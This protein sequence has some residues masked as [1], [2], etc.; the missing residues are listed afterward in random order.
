MTNQN[1]D[2]ISFVFFGTP[3]V[4]SKTLDVLKSFRLTPKLIVTNPDRPKGRG[5]KLAPSPTATW[6][7]EHG[8]P[9]LKPEKIDEEFYTKISELDTDIFIVVAY[10]KILP[11]RLIDMPKYGTLNIHYSLLPKY[12]GASP[13]ESALLAGDNETGVSIQK[14]VL[15][16]DQGPIIKDEKVLIDINTE[17][18]ELRAILIEKGGELLANILPDYIDG[19]ITP[20]PQ[21][22]SLATYCSKIE[23]SDGEIDPD[24]DAILNW[25]KYRAYSGWPGVFFFKDGKRVK[26]TRAKFKDGKFLIERV[27]PEGKKEQDYLL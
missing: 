23:K 9:C 15:K 17:K 14:M 4:G 11:Q 6:A 5:L 13:V 10:G 1:N 19:K 2:K 18:E 27:V 7:E 3:E 12:R 8:I 25:N 24:G 26:I 22:E 21:D 16:M 20:I